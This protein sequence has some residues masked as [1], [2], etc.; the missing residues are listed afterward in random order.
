MVPVKGNKELRLTG[1][2]LLLGIFLGNLRFTLRK[3]RTF[4]MVY[5]R[6]LCVEKYAYV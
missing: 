1:M 2:T 3:Y 5:T 6:A 4:L